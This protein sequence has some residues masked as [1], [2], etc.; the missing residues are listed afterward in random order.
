MKSGYVGHLLHPYL[1]LSLCLSSDPLLF[2]PFPSPLSLPP[3]NPSHPFPPL[4]TPSHPFPPPPTPSHPFPQVYRHTIHH[5]SQTYLKNADDI[6]QKKF[7]EVQLARAKR[8]GGAALRSF[9]GDQRRKHRARQRD[10]ADAPRD[11]ASLYAAV[12]PAEHRQAFD[13][14]VRLGGRAPADALDH[15]LFVCLESLQPDFRRF[16]YGTAAGRGMFLENAYEED[17]CAEVVHVNALL[18]QNEWR[19]YVARQRVRE[20]FIRRDQELYGDL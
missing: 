8:Q 2:S 13:Q 15:V 16:M 12:T 3:P 18:L 5:L 9:V 11:I 4:P 10:S 19:A 7:L 6:R 1:S 17:L 14:A 20:L